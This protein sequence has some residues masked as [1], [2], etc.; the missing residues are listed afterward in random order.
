MWSTYTMKYY[1]VI[2]RNEVLIHAVPWM[3][4][5]NIMQCE[6]SQ[7]Q[8]VKCCMISLIRGTSIGKVT[9]TESQT[10]AGMGSFF[11]GRE[12]LF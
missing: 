1:S 2:A 11:T 12:F 7:L 4:L 8:K 10:D 6:I 3:K 9:E 5:E